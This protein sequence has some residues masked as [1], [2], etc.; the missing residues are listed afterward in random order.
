[1]SPSGCR[2]SAPARCVVTAC[3]SSNDAIGRR[4]ASDPRR[5]HRRHDRRRNGGAPHP[6]GRSGVLPAA[7]GRARA[8]RSPHRPAGPSTRTATGSSWRKAPAS[9]CWRSWSTRAS[10]APAS[11]RSLPATGPPATPTT[12]P[13][14]IRRAA[15]PSRPCRLPWSRRAL[16]PRT[17][18]TSTPTAPR[19]R[20]TIPSRRAPS[21]RSSESTR[22]S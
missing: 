20:S 6:A 19:R 9:S 8:T 18:T 10:A 12:S 3:A 4:L 13:R 11:R 17:S 1:M 21:R 2:P 5:E 22:Q 15:G 14:R 16:P 7:G